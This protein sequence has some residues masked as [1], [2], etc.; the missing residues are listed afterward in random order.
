MS[1]RGLAFFDIDGTLVPSMSSSGFLAERLGHVHE[2]DHAEAHYAAGKLTN[3]QVSVIDARGWRGASIEAID[4]WLCDLPL[5]A[6]I[7]V[8]VS[9]CRNNQIEPVLASLAW[10]PVSD[11]IARRLGFT[12]NGGPRVGISNSIYD[13]TVAE[14]FDEYDKRDRAIALAI[15]RHVPLERCCAI[16]DSR[17]DIPLFNALSASLALNANVTAQE[18]AT[19][20]MNTQNLGEIVPWLEEWV[21]SFR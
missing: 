18:A 1:I 19:A 9:W 7:D 4:G 21:R 14:H 16:G 6:D 20:A 3:A 10:Q 11:S 5:I 2:L 17:S 12:P 13:G 15:D 8:V